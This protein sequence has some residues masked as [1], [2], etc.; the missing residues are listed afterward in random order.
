MKKTWAGTTHTFCD[1][2]TSKQEQIFWNF[3]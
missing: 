1:I 2:S 3:A